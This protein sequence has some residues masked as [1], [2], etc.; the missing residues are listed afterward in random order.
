MPDIKAILAGLLPNGINLDA[1]VD[2]VQ[3]VKQGE[4]VPADA[5]HYLSLAATSVNGQP[6][7]TVAF[8]VKSPFA[9]IL[10]FVLG[11]V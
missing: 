11:R 2:Y 10:N 9:G 7:V 6:A 3:Y 8:K 1:F 5:T 4:S